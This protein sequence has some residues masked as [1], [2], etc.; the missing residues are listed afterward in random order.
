[1]NTNDQDVELEDVVDEPVPPQEIPTYLVDGIDRQDRETLRAIA[2][3]ATAR[4]RYLEELERQ[5]I[6]A[7]DVV[8]DGEE[9]VDQEDGAK[10]TIVTKKVKCGKDSCNS[11]PHGPY[12]YRA[13]RDGSKVVTEYVGPA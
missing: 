3:Y 10:G 6:D 7:D 8:D 13:Y 1:M 5:E 2:D 9:L 12:K 4:A 11:C